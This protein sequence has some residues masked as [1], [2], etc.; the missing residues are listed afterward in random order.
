MII[1]FPLCESYAQ[2][3]KANELSVEIHYMNSNEVYNLTGYVVRKKKVCIK[4][5]IDANSTHAQSPGASRTVRRQFGMC[6]QMQAL[7][8]TSQSNG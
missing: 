1:D 5:Q 4:L 6:S 8:H 2:F 7:T 3:M